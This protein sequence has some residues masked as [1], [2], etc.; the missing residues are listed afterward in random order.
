M[1]YLMPLCL[2]LMTYTTPNENMNCFQQMLS[3]LCVF[4]SI[5]PVLN[6]TVIILMDKFLSIL[7]IKTVLKPETMNRI[8]HHWF[9]A[10]LRPAAAPAMIS[11]RILNTYYFELSHASGPSQHVYFSLF[12]TRP[13]FFIYLFLSCNLHN[14]TAAGYER[15]KLISS[16]SSLDKETEIRDLVAQGRRVRKNKWRRGSAF[17]SPINLS[18]V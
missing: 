15:V 16:S 4:R 6:Q 3:H 14:C 12:K 9:L 10:D 7:F 18:F 2:P 8:F 11:T 13:F 5:S 17:L 1:C